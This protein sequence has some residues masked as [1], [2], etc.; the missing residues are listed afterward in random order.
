MAF[1]K[2]V[3]YCAEFYVYICLYVTDLKIFNIVSSGLAK[4]IYYFK[5]LSIDC[6]EFLHA[7]SYYYL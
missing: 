3:F 1:K 6:F 4:F 5:S 2:F 7:Q